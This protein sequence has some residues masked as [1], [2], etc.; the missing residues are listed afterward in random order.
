MKFVLASSNRHKVAELEILF[1][2][3]IS[4]DIELLSLA[5]VGIDG[6]I[7]ENGTTFE[8]NALI[9]AKRAAESGY[10][11]IGDDSGLVVAAL[12]GAPGIYSARYA[13]EHGNDKANNAKL[14][15]EL[16]YEPYRAAAFVCALACVFP[17]GSEPIVVTGSAAGE[18]LTEPRGEN[19]FGYDPLFWYDQYGK[20][21]AEM[22]SIEK[23][24]VSH[25]A[26]ATEKLGEKLTERF[27]EKLT[28]KLSEIVDKKS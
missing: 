3:Y 24:L 16:E 20:A 25:R 17:D 19:G 26:V 12:D 10:I 23:N 7:E 5:D 14:L 28:E 11:G 2:A 21:F 18:I 15:K 13:G 22:N 8:E 4:E 1:K 9:K 6:D 27:G